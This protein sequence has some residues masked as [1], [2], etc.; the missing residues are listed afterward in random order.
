[1][2]FEQLE[3]AVEME[4]F[5]SGFRSRVGGETATFDVKGVGTGTTVGRSLSLSRLDDG[6]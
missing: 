4:T 6:M 2:E 1:M 5:E 3:L